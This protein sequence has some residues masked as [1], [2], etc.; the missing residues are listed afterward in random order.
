MLTSEHH[1]IDS[2]EFA[3][4]RGV[5][6]AQFELGLRYATGQGVAPDYVSAHKWFN[7]AALRGVSEARLHRADLAREMSAA[8]ISEAQ[9]QAREWLT[10]H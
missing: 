7:I 9:R 10:R 2:Y 8:E 4:D 3:A 1:R 5:P 6:E